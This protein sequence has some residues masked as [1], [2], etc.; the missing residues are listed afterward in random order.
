MMQYIAW[1]SYYPNPSK[2]TTHSCELLKQTPWR[3]SISGAGGKWIL[4]QDDRNSASPWSSS[5][6]GGRGWGDH[7]MKNVG[8]QSSQQNSMTHPICSPRVPPLLTRTHAARC[9]TPSTWSETPTCLLSPF[10]HVQLFVTLC[11]V[12]RQAPLSMGSPGRNTRVDCQA[13]LQG[14]FPTQGLNPHLLCLLHW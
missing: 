1:V 6:R 5:R 2:Y 12:A 13:L 11:T 10:S 14:T 9:V 8:L 7:A 3:V 4:S